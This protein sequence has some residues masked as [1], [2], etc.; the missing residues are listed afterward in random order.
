MDA[1]DFERALSPGIQNIDQEI[2]DSRM[3]RFDP[4]KQTEYDVYLAS[5]VMREGASQKKAASI[6]VQHFFD[7]I[8]CLALERGIHIRRL[9]AEAITPQG[10]QICEKQLKLKGLHER[11]DGTRVYAGGMRETL[12]HIQDDLSCFYPGRYA[13]LM[14]KYGL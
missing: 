6:L 5:I 2:E 3:L 1:R 12:R 9:S 4:V 14:S 10:R 8:Q 7:F 13:R 11:G